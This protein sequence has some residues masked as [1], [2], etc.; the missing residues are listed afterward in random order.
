MRAIVTRE[1]SGP[2]RLLLERSRDI[3]S[4]EKLIEL[5]SVPD[6]RLLLKS[7]SCFIQKASSSAI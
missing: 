2:E 7:T 6:K 3:R 1:G 5:G 4:W